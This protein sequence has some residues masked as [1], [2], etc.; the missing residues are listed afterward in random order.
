MQF[1]F[2]K[3]VLDRV[4]QIVGDTIVKLYIVSAWLWAISVYFAPVIFDKYLRVDESLSLE[5]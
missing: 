3:V 2:S 1:V 5:A 4:Y